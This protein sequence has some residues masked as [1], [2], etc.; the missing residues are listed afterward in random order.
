VCLLGVAGPF[1]SRL[2][3]SEIASGAP[4]TGA[5]A[6]GSPFSP[7]WPCFCTT[8]A[9]PRS[10]RAPWRNWK[11][12][13]TVT[14]F[15]PGGRPALAR[16]PFEW[17]GLV[18]TGEFYA[19]ADVNLEE[20][21]TP[22]ALPS[23]AS[24]NRALAPGRPPRSPDPGVSALRPVPAMA[25]DPGGSARECRLVEVFDLRFGTPR[26]PA[27]L[28]SALVDSRLRV[29]RTSFQFGKVRPK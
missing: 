26:E 23:S 4:A 8:A 17:R 15:P 24:P 21:S 27:F 20:D 11:R 3:G 6:S 19:L 25:R 22:P 7:C 18:E 10:T 1:V 2:V 28:A 16:H 12:V 9:G 5:T 29:E 13:S 14:R